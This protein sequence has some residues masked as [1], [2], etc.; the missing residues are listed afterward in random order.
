VQLNQDGTRKLDTIVASETLLDAAAL[1]RVLGGTVAEKNGRPAVDVSRVKPNLRFE[2]VPP[3]TDLRAFDMLS[4]V[5][6]SEGAGVGPTLS[7]RLSTQTR[8]L[9]ENDSFSSGPAARTPSDCW[10]EYLFPYENFLIYGM[11]RLL[12]PIESLALIFQKHSEGRRLW[13]AEI[14][15]HRRDR[16]RGPRLTD[17]GLLAELSLNAATPGEA[18]AHFKTRTKPLHIYN[19]LP[20]P[21]SDWTPAKADDICRHFVLGFDVNTPIDWRINPNGYL[22]WQ[23]AFNRHTWF[24]ELLLAIRATGDPKYVCALDEIWLS[25]IRDN[26][27]PDGHNGG[28]DPAW[29][30]LSTAVRIYGSWLQAWFGLLHEPHFQDTT[31]VEILKSLF[32]H[33]E[34]LLR[35]QGYGCNWL[36]V[37]SRVL[38]ALGQLF[39]EFHRAA[40]WKKDGLAR[41]EQ[42]VTRQIFPDGA[43]FELSPIYHMMASRGFL[44]AYELATLNGTPLPPAFEERLPG[45]FDYIAGMMRPDGS[46]P[47]VNDSGG[48]RKNSGWTARA[49]LEYG[50]RLFSRSDLLDH[51]KGLYAGRSRVFPDAGMAVLASGTGHDALWMLFDGGHPGATHRH[52]DALSL[53]VF[54]HGHPFI[55][56]PGITG[57]LR[58]DW[59]AYYRTSFA[60]NTVAVNGQDQIE[61]RCMPAYLAPSARETLYTS[62]GED[63]DFVRA[64]YAGGYRG[65]LDD[66]VHTR[67]VLFVRNGYWI[68]FDDVRGDGI[69]DIEARFQF[70]PL[71]IVL[72]RRTR[73]FRTLRQNLPNV[74]VMVVDPPKG[75]RLK[76]V[77]GATRPVGGWVSD[78]EDYPAPQARIRVQ[79]SVSDPAAPIRLITLIVPFAQGVNSG[80]R[81]TRMAATDDEIALD[82]RRPGKP[83]ERVTYVWADGRVSLLRSA[84]G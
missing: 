42:E 20:E 72:D 36:V 12:D 83:R 4:V 34:H 19:A 40:S 74:E 82:I 7:V 62:F 41:L 47:S 54:A 76:V 55:V 8:G 23:H 22:E 48:Y 61:S 57:Y 18:L 32:G 81:C 28:G 9:P 80:L 60:H 52:D 44:E 5:L 3:R 64:S 63:S 31:R 21:P 68:V 10:T 27:E 6:F 56:D 37:E 13:L 79:N 14:R 2:F 39:P 38:F 73:I 43:D 25:W 70:V 84:P 59:T 67:A 66:V 51:P 75:T 78:G 11:G 50:S 69:T 1:A 15:A 45:T 29:E 33:A 30:T 77:T 65:G 24:T 16:A 35:Y 71:R 17:E 26:P 58:D 53:E 46:L 49:F